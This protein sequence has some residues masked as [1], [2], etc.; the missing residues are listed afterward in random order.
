M[1]VVLP[2]TLVWLQPGPE[3][4]DFTQPDMVYRR[5]HGEVLRHA[6]VFHNTMEKI[7]SLRPDEEYTYLELG[8]FLTDV[9]QFRDPYAHMLAK[10]TIWARR[11]GQTGFW[12]CCR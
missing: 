1:E 2:T 6:E 4:P 9:S 10:R 5:S 7:G 11:H 12:Q 3:L 8:N